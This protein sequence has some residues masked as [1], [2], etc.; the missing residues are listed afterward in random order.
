MNVPK[1]IK[2]AGVEYSI[3]VENKELD[4][5]R[6]YGIANYITSEILLSTKYNHRDRSE[7]SVEQ[8]FWHEALHAMLDVMQ[9]DDLNNNEKFVNTLSSFIHQIV[10]DNFKL[11]TK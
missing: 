10:S 1:K 6:A 3:K 5:D 2:I 7:L 9:E 8:T 4:K 11:K